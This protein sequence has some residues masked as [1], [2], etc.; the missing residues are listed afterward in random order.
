MGD[1]EYRMRA[2]EPIEVN[3]KIRYLELLE[4]STVLTHKPDDGVARKQ[5]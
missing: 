3:M 2:M 5:E 4:I 1:D